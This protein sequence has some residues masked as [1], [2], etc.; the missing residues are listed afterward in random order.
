[1]LP[2]SGRPPISAVPRLLPVRARGS[3]DSP[4]AGGGAAGAASGDPKVQPVCTTFFPPFSHWAFR[5]FSPASI[6]ASV[7]PAMF[8][9]EQETR[10]L[11][12]YLVASICLNPLCT[13]SM[14]AVP[15]HAGVT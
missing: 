1:M 11:Y 2:S 9:R 7:E 10:P 6:P 14:V 12:P 13:F 3:A 5:S 4:A 15:S 8:A